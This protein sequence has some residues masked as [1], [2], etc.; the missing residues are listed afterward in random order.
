M[1][2]LLLVCIV[3][4]IRQTL[5]YKT[6]LTYLW[7]F[8][9]KICCNACMVTLI[10]APKG[11]KILHNI[12]TSWISMINLVKWVLSKYHTLFMKMALDAATIPSIQ[13]FSL[14]LFTDVETLLGLN[15]M[16]PLLKAVHSLIKFAQLKDVFVYDFIIIVKICERDVYRMFYDSQFSFE[17]DVFINFKAFINTTH[18]NINLCWITNLNTSIDHLAFEFVDN[19]SWPF[20]QIRLVHLF[21][22]QRT[23]MELLLHL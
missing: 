7:F 17:G 10:I 3:G 20:L 12:K 2:H 23:Y 19:T 13:P 8:A 22:L 4:L 21:L 18:D 9:L 6:S 11:N 16:M 5:Q 1:L 14:S 15:A